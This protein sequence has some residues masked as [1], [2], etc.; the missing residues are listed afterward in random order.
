MPAQMNV[1]ETD[2]L[3]LHW[4]EDGDPDGMPVLF[5]NSLG[6]DLRLWDAVLPLL[7]AG[8]RFIRYDKRGH[9]LSDCPPGPYAMADLIGEAEALIREIGLD[10]VIVVGLSIGGMIAQGLA[11]RNPGLVRAIVLSCTAARMGTA[12]MWETRIAAIREGGLESIADAVM[13]RWFSPSFR[14]TPAVAPWRA[15]CA[16]TPAEGYLGCCAALAGANLTETTSALTLPA[17]VIAGAEDGASPPELV[18]GTADLIAGSR[19]HVIDGAG[20]LPPV[21]APEAYAALV[22]PFLTEIANG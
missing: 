2:S 16:R 22:A 14:M 11:A 19:F 9:G 15:M 18:K 13:E 10:R 6:T 12:E 20:H 1:F 8:F 17:L 4:R 3:R 7:P 5:S 21:E